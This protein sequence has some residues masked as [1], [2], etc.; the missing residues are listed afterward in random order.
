MVEPESAIPVETETTAG[1]DEPAPE[2]TGD[3]IGSVEEDV[4]VGEAEE[5]VVE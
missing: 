4:P 1:P 2:T 3:E 5:A